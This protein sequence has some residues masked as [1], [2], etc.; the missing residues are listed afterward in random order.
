MG[1]IFEELE[2][3]SVVRIA[4]AY[5]AVDRL[6]LQI[7]DVVRDIFVLPDSVSASLTNISETEGKGKDTSSSTCSASSFAPGLNRRHKCKSKQ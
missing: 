2:R 6:V 1:Q 3:R 5:L 7:L 4:A